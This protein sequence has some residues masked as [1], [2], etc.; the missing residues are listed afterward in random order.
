MAAPRPSRPVPPARGAAGPWNRF[1]R[2]QLT[3]RESRVLELLVEGLS[4]RQ[5]GQALE[6]SEHVAK[7]TVA[8]VLAKLDCPTAPRPPRSPCVR[9]SWARAWGRRWARRALL[10]GGPAPPRGRSGR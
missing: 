2:R 7:R 6:V 8:I 3:E 5:I 9:G 1:P 4:N 10:T